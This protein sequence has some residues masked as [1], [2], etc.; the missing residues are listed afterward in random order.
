M[1]LQN[2]DNFITFSF[3]RYVVIMLVTYPGTSWY[4]TKLWI[5]KDFIIIWKQNVKLV[6]QYRQHSLDKNITKLYV[7]K[8]FL[9]KLQNAQF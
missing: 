7:L 5:N 1:N 2:I 6:F 3:H 9:N 8:G 4:F